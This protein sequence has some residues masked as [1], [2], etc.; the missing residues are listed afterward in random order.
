MGRETR[1][2]G[3]LMA[4]MTWAEYERRIIRDS[5]LVFLPVG[6]L[7]QHGPHLPLGT[8][9]LLVA[10]IAE[11]LAERVNAVVAPTIAYGYKSQLKTGGG[12]HFCGTTSL[13]SNT[14]S[15]LIRDLIREL[16]RH[17]ARKIAVINGHY[18]NHMFLVE[19][20]DLAMREMRRD[21]IRDAKIL[22]LGYFEFASAD[23]LAK[24]FPGGFPGYDLEHA[25][26]LETSLC[27]SLFPDLVRSE[28][29]PK[30]SAVSFPLYDVFPPKL[31][32]VPP[33]G[34]L[35][36]A[37]GAS[38]EKGELLVQDYLRFIAEALC[39]EFGKETL[40]QEHSA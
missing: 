32:W 11:R 16:V 8:D 36:P 21:G 38:R 5:A 14:L 3:A 27:L 10:A 18:E 31:E 20:I 19:G 12:N 26:V 13:D 23:T 34:V 15:S 35:S 22:R 25:A 4:H 28:L 6:A 30:Q 39:T 2:K 40:L 17:G 1:G 24:V 29:I 9:A 7:E 33:S 37:D